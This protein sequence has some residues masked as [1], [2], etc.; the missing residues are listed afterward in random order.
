[1]GPPDGLFRELGRW[2]DKATKRG[3]PC[4]FNS[5]IIPEWL[6]DEIKAAMDAVGVEAAFSFL[7]QVDWAARR[8]A[9]RRIKRKIQSIMKD[10]LAKAERSVSRGQEF[11]YAG[12]ADELRAAIQ[13]ELAQMVVGEALSVSAD[14][15]I[16][17][18]PAIINTE[19]LQWAREY[20]Y[21][22]VSGL[23]NTT[24]NQISQVVQSFVETPGMTQ[25]DITKLLEPAFGPVRAEMIATT[26]VTRSYAA[27][28][29]E[30]QRQVNQTGLQMTRI[31]QTQ[32]D[33]LVCDICGPLNQRPEA[34]WRAEYPD[35]PPAHPNCRCGITLTAAPEE[36]IRERVAEAER[37]RAEMLGTETTT[38]STL[39]FNTVE[40]AR[41]WFESKG[42]QLGRHWLSTD[43][44]LLEEIAQEHQR[45]TSA[46]YETIV[47][48]IDRDD[49]T[50]F[51]GLHYAGRID[52]NPVEIQKAADQWDS[53]A[54]SDV[55][56]FVTR[57]SISSTYRHEFGHSVMPMLPTEYEYRGQTINMSELV[58]S[59]LERTLERETGRAS[60][61]SQYSSYA[62]SNKYEYWAE[63]FSK[64]NAPDYE[65]T[66]SDSW[67]WQV[68]E[69]VGYKE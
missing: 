64:L 45:L 61:A 9:E 65:R 21:E 67:W 39:A 35:G 46:G 13:P 62:T 58:N 14:V 40:D 52:L 53:P 43:A 32:N 31:W 49:G 59:T 50:P 68:F 16:I 29:N 1:M 25:G 7:K 27:A 20:S 18:D 10:Y 36:A 54:F 6:S 3:R 11:D 15:G 19:A 33:E 30:I 51:Q 8:Q 37:I 63:A 60:V 4:D 34:D 2:R 22:L 47:S 41:A 5:D 26:E 56:A 17:F 44:P 66:A 28:T 24:R 42:V 57:P 48:V 12:M 55:K 69:S 38:G 23:T